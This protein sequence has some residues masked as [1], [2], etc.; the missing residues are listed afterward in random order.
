MAYDLEEQEQI[1]Q[2]KAWWAKY[3]TFLLTLLVIVLGVVAAWRG[4][5]WYQT[6]QATKA[7]GYF[8]ALEQ[9]TR[10]PGDDSVA[11]VNA[12]MKTLRDEFAKTDYAARG[13]LLAATALMEKKDVAGARS[14]L[15][16]LVQSSHPALVPVARLRI[17][18]L[19]LDQ[20]D[21]EGALAQLKDPPASF[22]GMFAD[23]R[24]DIL[25]AQGNIA[26]AKD[27]WKH[28]MDLLG[29]GNPLLS[30]VKL[31]LDSTGG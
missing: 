5:Q 26:G 13:A 30:I 25:L 11:R 1:D 12:A 15:D 10:Q 21:Y 8:E 22:E 16:W 24:G 4:L 7:R 27:S 29:S 2:L 17:A 3:G 9:A 6:H 19:L 28:A 31:K 14:Q 18:G 20:K 23:R